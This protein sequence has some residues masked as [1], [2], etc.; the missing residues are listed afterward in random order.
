[1]KHN[2]LLG[3]THK[4]IHALQHYHDAIIRKTTNFRNQ[5]N[6]SQ[7]KEIAEGYCT[8]LEIVPY[9]KNI[10]I[11]QVLAALSRLYALAHD[12]PDIELPDDAPDISDDLNVTIA[13]WKQV[14]DRVRSILGTQVGYWAYFDPTEPPEST[15]E[16]VFGN[17]ADDLADIYKDI[18]PGLRAWATGDD[19]YLT[20]II[21]AWKFPPFGSHWGMHAVSALRALHPLFYLRGIQ[22]EQRYNA[23]DM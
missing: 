14:S 22:D 2:K 18:K 21:L 8:L 12:L 20:S 6:V 17:L 15:D 9:D 3:E 1:V 10:W 13:E 23:A 4:N 7:F 11:Q 5:N 19:R 16:P